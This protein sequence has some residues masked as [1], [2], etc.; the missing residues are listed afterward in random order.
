MIIIGKIK[1]IYNENDV[2]SIKDLICDKP[3]VDKEK[4]LKYLRSGTRGAVAA[5]YAKDVLTGD[6]IDGELCCYTDGKYAW[7][8]DTVYYFEKYNIKLPE[9]FIKHALANI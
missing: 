9:E 6:K 4:I 2:P 1:E 7:R 8:S 3:I 5:G